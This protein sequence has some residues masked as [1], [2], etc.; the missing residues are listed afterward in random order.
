MYFFSDVI[1]GLI[2]CVLDEWS[3]LMSEGIIFN[4]AQLASK[5]QVQAA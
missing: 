5:S 1:Y 3:G 4:P 2:V